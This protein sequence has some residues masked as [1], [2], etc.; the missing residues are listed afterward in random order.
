MARVT[1]GRQWADGDRIWLIVKADDS[2]PT[3][4]MQAR[5]VA[6]DAFAQMVDVVLS[7]AG[8]DLHDLDAVAAEFGIELAE[9][10]GD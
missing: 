4:L 5:L 6:A 8:E 7:P 3:A 10:E 1:M 2:S 9:D